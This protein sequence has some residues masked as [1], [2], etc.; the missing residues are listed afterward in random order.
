MP[1]P[2]AASVNLTG[3]ER[4][5]LESLLLEFDRSWDDGR[6]AAARQLPR[7]ALRPLALLE[8]V[9]VDL[10]KQW[11]RGRKPTVEGY[12]RLYPELGTAETV[13]P[14]LLLAEYQVRRR[15]GGAAGLDDYAR[16][17]PRRADELRGLLAEAGR[18]ASG[19]SLS[20]A[21]RQTVGPDKSTTPPGVPE[22]VGRYRVVKKLGQGGM[23]SVYLAEDAQLDRPVALKVPLLKGDDQASTRQRFLREAQAA[24]KLRHANICPVYDVGEADGV[25]YLTM[26]YVEGRPLSDF[27][28]GK[29]L[30]E[31][32]AILLVRKLALAL[33]EAHERGVVHRDLKPSNV[34]IDHRKEPVVMDFG[35]AQRVDTKGIRLTQ[36]GAVLGTPAY[37]SPEQAGGEVAAMG[38]RCD[39][40]GLGVMLYEMLTGRLPFEG[41]IGVVFAQVLTKEPEAPSSLRPGLDPRLEAVCLKA[42]AKKP[43]DR[44]ASMKDFATALTDCLAAGPPSVTAPPGA[45]P[46][47]KP[48]EPEDPFRDLGASTE[49]VAVP[50]AKDRRGK[51]ASDRRLVLAGAGLAAVVLAVAL[52]VVIVVRAGNYGSVHIKLPAGASGI[53]VE[54]NGDEIDIKGLDEPVRL[55]AG[56][57]L[58]EVK[59]KSFKTFTRRIVLSR[60]G[61]EEVEVELKPAGADE[62]KKPA[63]EVGDAGKKPLPDPPA[64]DELPG[65]VRR[66]EAE[67]EHK[68]G[69]LGL[70]LSRDGRRALSGSWDKTVRLWDVQTGRAIRTLDESAEVNCVAP[71]PDGRYAL[72]GTS[73]KVLRLWDAESGREIRK[74]QGHTQPVRSVA[75][76]PDGRL[77]LSG[78]EDKT[79][80]LWEVATGKEVRRFEGRQG[81]IRSVV[82]LPDGRHALSGS[83]GPPFIRLWRLPP[84]PPKAD[85]QPAAPPAPPPP[86][87]PEPPPPVAKGVEFTKVWDGAPH[88]AFTDLVRFGG[89]WFGTCHDGGLSP[90]GAVRVLTSP[91]GKTWTPAARVTSPRNDLRDPK[92]AVTPDGRLMLVM[93]AALPGGRVY[94]SLVSFSADGRRWGTPVEV[95][96]PNF[97]LGRVTWHRGTAYAAGH[98][99]SGPRSLRLYLS[100]DGRQFTTLARD[101]ADKDLPGEASLL[102]LPDDTCVCLLRRDNATG[103][104]GTAPPPHTTWTWKDL[105]VRLADPRLLLLPDGRVVAA[106]REYVP[107]AVQANLWWLDHRAGTLTRLHSFLSAGENSVTGLAWHDGLLWVSHTMNQRYTA[108]VYLAKLR[109][110]PAGPGSPDR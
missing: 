105:G 88:G 24:A 53:M 81:W 8:M 23:A 68:R 75:F 37:M 12:L 44:F 46:V 47:G 95:G 90:S 98:A 41:P 48:A 14:G 2:E 26:A 13:P 103:L 84:V 22:R 61:K 110:P 18:S 50:A 93:A 66:F 67:K 51:R 15:F 20:E 39:V 40:Y 72:S 36:E 1:T 109:V 73:D 57:H 19:S 108:T 82:F 56:E 54:V 30:P 5:R 91:D 76:S 38:P 25:P 34:M 6:L 7:D 92:L 59:G 55:K 21:N 33:Q 107:P 94:R 17:F 106:A 77:A 99:T 80:R 31:R 10:E 102:F 89:S 78:S 3:A 52:G 16:R 97:W 79:L 32:Q 87:K 35:L 70:A 42:M 85:A 28:R 64:R 83:D 27:L 11:Q 4:H 63:Q 71:S 101:L 96:E 100:K 43:A 69:V 60:G 62:G 65:E 9:K 74:L 104:L 86:V 45:P 49:A 29:A 58:L